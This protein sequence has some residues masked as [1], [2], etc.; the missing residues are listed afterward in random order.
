MDG[1]SGDGESVLEMASVHAVCSRAVGAAIE[2][3]RSS[4]R[5]IRVDH[6]VAVV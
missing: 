5:V 4:Q 6:V 1:P 2:Q 3:T